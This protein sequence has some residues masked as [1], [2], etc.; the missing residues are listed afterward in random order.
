MKNILF[1]LLIGL[2]ACTGENTNDGDQIV[3]IT[4]NVG[5]G[6][7][8]FQNNG[9][10]ATAIYGAYDMINAF[11]SPDGTNFAIWYDN[12]LAFQLDKIDL[13]NIS[14]RE[15]ADNADNLV[16]L[17][18]KIVQ[19]VIM[20]PF[21]GET[22]E[23]IKLGSSK[24]EVIAAFG[25]PDNVGSLSDTYNNLNMDIWYSNTETIRRIDM[26]M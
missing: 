12:G 25:E 22:K 17:D 14:L 23:G 10:D 18:Q 5:V 2:T 16:D 13:G 11:K 21:R 7:L 8:T 15:V 6:D 3:S 4:P 24:A 9:S 20:S 19:I 1:I 26:K